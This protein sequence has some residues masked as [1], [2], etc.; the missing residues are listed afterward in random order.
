MI[1]S[2]QVYATPGDLVSGLTAM[3]ALPGWTLVSCKNKYAYPSPE[4]YADINTS[5]LVPVGGGLTCIAEVQFHLRG[6]LEAKDKAHT[7]YEATREEIP[8][9][10]AS[11]SP[12]KREA[13]KKFIIS[14]LK[15]SAVD[16]AV[17]VMEQKAQGLFIYA[18]LLREHLTQQQQRRGG[19]EAALTLEEVAAL[20]AGLDEMYQENFQRVFPAASESW[21]ACSSLVALILAAPEPL[22]QALARSVLRWDAGTE[23]RLVR[24]TALL[25]P[26]KEDGCFH[27]LHKTVAD[28]LTSGQRRGQ[29]YFISTEDIARAH[30]ELGVDAQSASSLLFLIHY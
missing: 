21:L 23:E 5:F 9:V 10:F 7:Y 14:R 2:L 4:G 27:V 11:Q 6:V 20:P 26:V 28:W 12:D 29:K 22:P 13:I 16:A 25:F 30:K 1:L 8:K 15:S 3:Q 18:R 17:D 19:A 24:D